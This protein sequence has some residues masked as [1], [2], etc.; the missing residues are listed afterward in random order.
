[1]SQFTRKGQ[2]YVWDIHCEESFRELKKKLTTAPVLILPN[3]FEPFAVY[4]D[5]SKMGLDGVWMEDG[6]VV[7]YASR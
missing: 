6:K 5:A 7:A 1:M 4:Y 3:P 2:A